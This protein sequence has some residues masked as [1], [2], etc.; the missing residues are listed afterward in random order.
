MVVPYINQS[1]PLWQF[2]NNSQIYRFEPDGQNAGQPAYEGQPEQAAYYPQ[3]GYAQDGYY[4]EQ[5]QYMGQEAYYSQEN[6][7]EPYYNEFPTEQTH[8]DPNDPYA[9][10]GAYQ[11]F[12]DVVGYEELGYDPYYGLKPDTTYNPMPDFYP[13]YDTRE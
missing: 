7:Q 6:Y 2:D 9:Q 13:E 12:D 10:Y 5:D 3:E 8:I 1:Q 11:E 4:Q